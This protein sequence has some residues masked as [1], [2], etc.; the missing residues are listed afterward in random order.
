MRPSPALDYLR[1]GQTPF[2]RLPL[3]EPGPLGDPTR[4]VHGGERAR[5]VLLGVPYDGGTTY[6]PGAR[7][8]PYHVRRVSALLSS[9][10]PV[11]RIDTFAELPTLDGGN[12]PVSPF[13]AA[14]MR[15]AVFA[16]IMAVQAAGAVP[17]VVGGDHSITIPILRA[18]HAQH[19]PVCVLHVDAHFDLT[20]A[21]VWGEDFHH[22]T[23]IRHGLEQGWIAEGGLFQVG[24]RGGWKD[25]HE[26]ERTLAHGGRIYPA[27]LFEQRSAREIALEIRQEVGQRPLYLSIDV[28]AIDP[29]FAPGT[30]TAVPGGL[31]SREAISLLTHLVGTKIVGMDLVEVSPPHDHA[32]LTSMLA[33]HLLFEGSSLLAME[34]QATSRRDNQPPQAEPGESETRAS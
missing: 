13:D 16:E 2:F 32:D 24:L 19:G 15:E 7:V 20:E 9:F 5:A 33:A 10:H 25:G 18:I 31:S 1:H 3:A 14:M 27:A 29:A 34:I 26:A 12:V 30:G 17:F 6:L 21:S 8:A 22:G 28:D 4:F 11:H 23:P